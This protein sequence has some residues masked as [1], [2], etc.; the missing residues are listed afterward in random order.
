[1][2]DLLVTRSLSFFLL[3]VIWRRYNYSGYI[4]FEVRFGNRG[5]DGFL[6]YRIFRVFPYSAVPQLYTKFLY[7]AT[8]ERCC[9]L[10]LYW[11]IAQ[12][13]AQYPPASL[14]LSARDSVQKHAQFVPS[15]FPPECSGT[16]VVGG[17]TL[18]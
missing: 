3:V 14:P 18:A 5:F 16:P 13:V 2:S 17:D 6:R 12:Y 9:V 11:E 10:R 8:T 15:P 1:M 7:D 4:H